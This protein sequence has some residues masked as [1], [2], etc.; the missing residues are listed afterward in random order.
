MAGRI[1]GITIEFGGDTVKLE[2]ALKTINQSSKNVQNKLKDINKL[3]KFDPKNSDLLKQK[4]EA[5]GKAIDT[6]KEK[7]NKLKEIEKELAKD[8]GQKEKWEIVKREIAE[9]ENQLKSYKAQQIKLKEEMS[10]FHKVGEQVTKVGDGFE[11]AGKKLL[12]VTAGIS[13]LSYASKKAWD[14]VDEMLDI[15][16]TKTGETGDNLKELQGVAK[17]VFKSEVAPSAVDAGNAV[18][19]LNTRFGFTG[20]ILRDASIDFLKFAEVTGQDVNS[21]VINVSRAMGDA[22]IDAK[23]YKLVLDQLTVAGQKSGIEVGK[24]TE[25]LTKFGAPMRQLGFDTKESIA[26]FASWEKAGVN[27]DIAF[28][29]MKKAIG[30]W[31]KEGKDAKVE[32][33]KMLDEIQKAPTLAD[34]T[35]KAIE[36]FGQKAGPDLADAIK[37]GRFEFNE[38]TKALEEGG[39]SL[40]TTFENT[41]DP[42]DKMKQ[43]F[44]NIK[45]TGAELA[46][47]AMQVL[48]PVFQN[49]ANKAKML[50]DWF[51]KLTDKQK[52]MIVKILGIVAAVA[53]VLIVL[54]KLTQGI[55]KTID[56]FSKIHST[57]SKLSSVGSKLRGGITRIFALVKAH[58]FV[59]IAVAIAALVAGLIYAYKNCE[60]F[61]NIVDKAFKVLAK[62]FESF[63]KVVTK[64]WDVIKTAFQVA[65]NTVINPIITWIGQKIQG[66]KE[67]FNSFKTNC[68]NIFKTTWN[69]IKTVWDTFWAV[70]ESV[71][72]VAW[73]VL[74]V[75]FETTFNFIKTIFTTVWNKIKTAWDVFWAVFEPIFKTAWEVLKVNFEI[76]FN[77]I[78][79]IFTTIWNNIKIVFETILGVIKGIWDIFAGIFTGD[80][81]RVWEEI[82]GIFSSIWNGI[83]NLF[84]NLLNGM[85]DL[86]KNIFNGLVGSVKSI[87]GQVPGA[88]SDI[89]NEAVEFLE[90][91]DL[92]GIGENII[93]GLINGIGS[94]G[95]ALVSAARNIANSFI[96]SIKSFFGI[97]SPSRVMAGFGVNIGEGLVNGVDEMQDKVNESGKQISN[98]FT[99]GYEER[100]K[101]FKNKITGTYDLSANS[102]VLSKFNQA[103]QEFNNLKN[104]LNITVVSELDGKAIAKGTWKYTD[105]YQ[106]MNM[107]R[108]R[109]VKA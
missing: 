11:Q 4:Q 32:F 104:N 73:E 63:M 29:G 23:D 24:L 15:V 107:K 98:A 58:P 55:G 18:G 36:V 89:W 95:G 56:S 82:K 100:Q 72:K 68:V 38:M 34:A 51:S 2:N 85:W 71:F 12:P 74:K 75:A 93:Q 25:T 64:G 26:L 43:A 19:E 40:E 66:L 48:A 28:S 57:I 41:R 108:L 9:T 53:P 80:W 88:I 3:L 8:P 79:T 14:E 99:K 81:N 33:R 30:N 92:V 76:T 102:N 61:R 17:E 21:A 6:S 77:V 37:G 49:L 90:S 22:G 86:A 52:E 59:A 45:V 1:K 54:G 50:S 10:V 67:S 84:S 39:G 97:N 105:G 69:V 83:K 60:K 35:T 46:E 27:T 20:D 47:V 87:F 31:A 70:F 96:G 91:I 109:S 7:L 44:N 13:A 94:M 101:N 42:I 62:T 103:I 78:K 16:V 106:G 5:L 65:W